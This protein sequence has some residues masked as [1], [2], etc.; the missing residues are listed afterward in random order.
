MATVS[1]SYAAVDSHLISKV[2]PAATVWSWVGEV[3]ASK[4][5]VGLYWAHTLA[6]KPTMADTVEKRMMKDMERKC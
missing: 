6:A 3:R 2:D 4:P 1:F 5:A